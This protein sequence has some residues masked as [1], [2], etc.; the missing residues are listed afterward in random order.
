[1]E[2][3]S[4]EMKCSL[5]MFGEGTHMELYFCTLGGGKEVGGA[6]LFEQEQSPLTACKSSIWM[7][8]IL[9][10]GTRAAVREEAL[11]T[12]ILGTN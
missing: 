4:S 8:G 1:M 12:P 5:E 11:G 7:E 2:A 9:L 10:T 3:R 6:V